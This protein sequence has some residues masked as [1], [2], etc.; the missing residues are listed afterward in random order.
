[1]SLVVSLS[2]SEVKILLESLVARERHMA[3]LCATS[4]DADVVAETGNDLIEL[5]LFLRSV[6]DQAVRQFGERVLNFNREP[7]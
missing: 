2:E 1:M 3:A 6:R 5:R 4:D 7:L